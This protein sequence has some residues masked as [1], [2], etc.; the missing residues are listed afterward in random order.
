M[1]VSRPVIPAATIILLREA[2]G[3]RRVGAELHEGRWIDVGTPQRLAA[4]DAQLRPR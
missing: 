1:S 3:R 2:A 4:L